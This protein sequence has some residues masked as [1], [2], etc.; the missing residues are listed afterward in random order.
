MTQT[1][2]LNLPVVVLA[3]DHDGLREVF[4]IPAV[5]RIVTLVRRMGC[6]D[7]HLCGRVDAFRP[8][9]PLSAIPVKF[10]PAGDLPALEGILREIAFPSQTGIL[11]VRADTVLD[12]PTLERYAS[13]NSGR[14]LEPGAAGCADG[15]CIASAE[16]LVPA[17]IRMWNSGT[18]GGASGCASDNGL[19]C[20]I[21]G[22]GGAANAEDKLVEAL[23]TRTRESD[24]FLARHVSRRVS[25]PLSRILART[26]V[27]PNQ[28]TVLNTLLGLSAAYL[29]ARGGYW[30]QLAG[31]LLFVF[32]VIAD[33]IDG[34][35]ARLKLMESSFGHMLDVVT[36]NIVHFAIFLGLGAGLSRS[37]G[38]PLYMDL[39]WLLLGGFLINIIVVYFRI[40]KKSPEELRASPGAVRIMALL[41]NRDFAYL[42]LALALIGQLQ[43]F[44]IGA[45]IGSYIFAAVLLF[46]SYEK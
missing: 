2:G 31:S 8:L 40:L 17:A 5:R 43:L 3:P 35:I 1:E 23:G 22:P 16:S 24:G 10:H 14:R 34:E 20:T 9:L 27:T 4:G 13:V 26:P 42:V 25:Q 11:L 45:A 18:P 12:L 44:M 28:V 21:S 32:C 6:D 38:N 33:G 29:L 41:S 46:F 19:P 36:D 37:S 39:F 15:I 7:I 30:S